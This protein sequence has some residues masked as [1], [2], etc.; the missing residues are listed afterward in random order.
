MQIICL[1]FV[2]IMN[3]EY[4]ISKNKDVNYFKKVTKPSAEELEQHKIYLKQNLKKN[5]FS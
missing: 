3:I 1:I 4:F 5:F 2:I